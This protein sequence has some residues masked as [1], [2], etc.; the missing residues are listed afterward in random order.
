M[1]PYGGGAELVRTVPGVKGSVIAAT[2]TGLLF[3]SDNGGASWKNMPFPA[4]SEGVLHAL[5][6]DP[7]HGDIWYAGMEGN[8]AHTSGVYRTSDGGRSW[9]LLPATKGI[10]VWSLAFALSNPDVMALGA[11]SGVYLTHNSGGSWKRISPAEDREL[12]PVVSLAFD[13]ADTNIIYAGTTHLPWRTSDGGATWQSIH[14]GMIDDSDVFS[15]E[16]DPHQPSRVLASACSG[17]YASYDAAHHWARLKTP[18]GAF[19]TYFTTLDPGHPGTIFAGTSDGLLKS[20]NDGLTWRKVSP[21]PVKS[22]AFDPFIANRVFFAATDVG[23]LLSTDGGESLRESNV[24]FDHR[25][26]TSIADA[27]NTLYLSGPEGFYWT[28]TLGRRWQKIAPGTGGEKMLILSA[29]PDAPHTLFAAG[30]RGLFESADGGHTWKPREGL[31]AGIRVK[32]ILPRPRGVVLAGTDRGLFRGN[33]SG[34]WSRV[35]ASPVEWVQSTGAHALAALTLNAALVSQDEGVTW[36]GCATPASDITWYGMALDPASST[37]A[38]AAT[39]RGLFRS[40]DGCRS[41][42]AVAGG[43]EAATV[44][45]VL[46]HPTR[47]KE[48]FL[49]QGGRVFRSTNSGESWEPLSDRGPELWPSSLL[50]LASAPDRLFALVRGRGIFSTGP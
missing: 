43:L 10:A 21:H 26:F 23:L 36:R 47:A 48:A 14:T 38:L 12:R 42:T 37:T 2:H 16:V 7:R 24:G 6:I 49:A 28:D 30:Y 1:G 15:I 41:W 31:P 46:F 17:A 3:R 4:Q 35:E 33:L 34:K 19:R 9:T 45:V 22:I 18:L 25:T 44:G 11:D 29:A 40:I 20:A 32:A 8:N 5:E 13:P 50:V 27:G 39:S